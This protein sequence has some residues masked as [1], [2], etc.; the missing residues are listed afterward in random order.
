MNEQLTAAI[1]FH[2]IFYHTV[3]ING[4]QN[5]LQNIFCSVQKPKEPHRFV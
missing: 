4:D 5:I 3:E 1:D 2:S